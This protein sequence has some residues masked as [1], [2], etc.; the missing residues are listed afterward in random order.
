[1]SE[2]EHSWEYNPV[3]N[4]YEFT[5]RSKKDIYEEAVLK[6]DPSLLAKLKKIKLKEKTHGGR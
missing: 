3:W 4:L 5:L 1:M 2:Y 6:V